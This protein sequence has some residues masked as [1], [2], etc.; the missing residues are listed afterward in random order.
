MAMKVVLFRYAIANIH[1]LHL[2]YPAKL[3]I[4]KNYVYNKIIISICI[5]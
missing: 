5:N 3:C 2:H 4:N 1:I